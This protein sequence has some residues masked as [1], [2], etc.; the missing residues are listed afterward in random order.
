[1]K[2]IVIIGGGPSGIMAALT[3]AEKT[4]EQV[5]ITIVERLEKI[6]KKILA[7]GN[8][9]CNYT[10]MNLTTKK[11][12]NPRFVS[13]TFKLMTPANLIKYFDSIGMMSKELNEGRVYP[14][15]ENAT[16][17]LDILR[18]N[19]NKYNIE[20]K[21]N[22]E[23]DKVVLDKTKKYQI[24]NKNQRNYFIT[25]DYVVFACGGC[26]API[27]GSNGS[28]YA[29]LKP[30]K[31]KTTPLTPGLVGIKS[32]VQTLKALDGVRFKCNVGIFEKKTKYKVFSEDGEVQFKTDGISGI[33]V[34][35][36]SSFIARNPGN[37]YIGLD[38]IPRISKDDV[39]KMLNERRNMFASLEVGSYL[40]G[41]LPKQLGLAVL[42]KA[43][44]SLSGY[45]KEL[46]STNIKKI[47]TSIKEFN[48]DIKGVYDFKNSQ[49]TV[50]GIATDEISSETLKLKKMNNAYICGEMIDIDGECGGYNLTWAFASGYNV[51]LN[52]V[53]ELGKDAK[54]K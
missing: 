38:L 32:D 35:Q 29:L 44:C 20:I 53:K 41:M 19:L 37:Y 46:S 43:N 42:K 34:M 31:I 49:V 24:F 39:I 18:F 10:N 27:L 23:V 28:G 45:I 22:F 12:N 11:Y 26:S 9:K 52:I 54:G 7:T 8:G 3:I 13:P 50:G 4:K 14:F 21:S 16:T 48:L 25:A 15:T 6:G 36:A 2:E 51:G 5:K 47:A 1:M 30:Y 40:I 33:C 17:V